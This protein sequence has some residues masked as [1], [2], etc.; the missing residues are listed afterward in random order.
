MECKDFKKV[1]M[2]AF[3]Y[4]SGD[5]NEILSRFLHIFNEIIKTHVP[6][7][8]IKPLNNLIKPW[9]TGGLRK[10]INIRNQLFKKWRITLNSYYHY[11]YKLYHYII[12]STYTIH[13]VHFITVAYL[14]IPQKL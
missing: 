4:N 7:K 11:E 12:V 14:K 3:R 1:D 6:L 10:S 5:A 13:I 2:I 9:V 8:M